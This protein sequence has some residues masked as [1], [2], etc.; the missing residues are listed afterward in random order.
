MA[1]GTVKWFNAEKGYGFIAVDGGGPDVFVHY[2]A[3]QTSGFRYARRGSAR[4]VRDHA[5]PEGPAGR[6]G[7]RDLSPARTD[8]THSPRH[9]GAG[10]W[11]ASLRL[12]RRENAPRA[13]RRARHAP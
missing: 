3:I 11:R 6:R 12:S 7:R 2:S 4:R 5:G 13:C 8:A 9:L 10:G 1:Q